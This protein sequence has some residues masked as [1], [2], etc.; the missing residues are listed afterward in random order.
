MKKPTLEEIEKEYWENTNRMVSQ[1]ELFA[2]GVNYAIEYNEEQNNLMK[3]YDIGIKID[4]KEI[5]RLLIENV[6][7]EFSFYEL[8]LHR[9]ITTGNHAKLVYDVKSGYGVHEK[10][11][12]IS[13]NN[14]GKVV[15]EFVDECPWE[16]T[17]AEN[18]IELVIQN[19]L[20]FLY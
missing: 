14:M 18:E 1:I 2:A 4:V 16:D 5:H 13:I 20:L 12:E 15:V 3:I 9:V 6:W 17:S 19:Y 8:R 7:D 10:V 11:L